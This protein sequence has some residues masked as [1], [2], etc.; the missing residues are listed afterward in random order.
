M[1]P[2][3]QAVIWTI[4]LIVTPVGFGTVNAQPPESAGAA[5][6]VGESAPEQRPVD[7]RPFI[8]SL[9][10]GLH[11]AAGLVSV[12]C[13][14]DVVD[15]QPAPALR[16]DDVANRV[17]HFLAGRSTESSE[18]RI[19]E[20]EH[21]RYFS[22]ARPAL[23][24]GRSTFYPGECTGESL[25]GHQIIFSSGFPVEKPI[26]NVPIP[27]PSNKRYSCEPVAWLA[28]LD[29]FYGFLYSD[30]YEVI[31][32]E[33]HDQVYCPPEGYQ[34]I[35]HHLT[36][37]LFA[38][39]KNKQALS[40]SVA[41]PEFRIGPQSLDLPVPSN[42]R[43]NLQELSAASQ[44]Y[45]WVSLCFRDSDGGGA[46]NSETEPPPPVSFTTCPSSVP[47]TCCPYL[48]QQK[49][50]DQF[51]ATCESLPLCDFEENL[52]K[53]SAASRLFD[54]G[55][56][57]LRYGDRDGAK[58][59]FARVREMVPGSRVACRAREQIQQM[60]EFQRLLDIPISVNFRDKPL[61]E[62]LLEIGRMAKLDIRFDD[63]S[64]R[65][66]GVNLDSPVSLALEQVKVKSTLNLLLDACRL[67]YVL[68]NDVVK[69]TTREHVRSRLMTKLFTV[70]EKDYVDA[71]RKTQPSIAGE[72]DAPW[73]ERL[74]TMIC[75]TV[76]TKSWDCSGGMGTIYYDGT[77]NAIVVCQTG[78]ILDQVDWMFRS[79][80]VLQKMERENSGCAKPSS[81]VGKAEESQLERV[82]PT[83]PPIDPKI[84]DAL[85]KVLKES[86]DPTAPRLI[87]HV[88]DPPA[89]EEEE[90]AVPPEWSGEPQ[91]DD[92]PRL[93]VDPA[94]EKLT[95]TPE[96]EDPAEMEE[97]SSEEWS[98]VLRDA[99]DAIRAGLSVSV[100]TDAG[101]T[102][103][104]HREQFDGIEV[105]IAL[106]FGGEMFIKVSLAP[107]SS[108]DL[109]AAQ[110]AHNERILNWIESLNEPCTEEDDAATEE[111]DATYGDEPRNEAIP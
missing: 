88:E 110:R 20:L 36:G 85:E 22:G 87:I 81:N 29:R 93:F 53:L 65:E 37:G 15:E 73:H 18:G 64:L 19:S 21:G 38:L 75:N 10:I 9:L 106:G 55:V 57:W 7:M 60:E 59:F 24:R 111:E 47:S 99:V 92:I 1:S 30:D 84:I 82:V 71:S 51:R 17:F 5:N 32:V 46:K 109:R 52:K 62:A 12:D 39:R 23:E 100:D 35:S 101:P 83:L 89:T 74:I 13:L 2:R 43:K 78:E 86:G 68:E 33:L 76:E 91:E 95:I 107:E 26:A 31:S 40:E 54:K 61:K 8:R 79:F 27:D 28:S 25:L 94:E 69:I 103:V 105:E 49:E 63:E 97:L 3:L 58:Y 11:P 67:S 72:N 66:E 50:C 34:I 98:A 45:Y 42:F 90:S 48:K 70:E 44:I 104:P 102:G 77:R 41:N 56:T 96:D 14:V 4:A 80:N 16:L 6:P 108:G